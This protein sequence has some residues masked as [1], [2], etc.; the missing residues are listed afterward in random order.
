METTKLNTEE[1]KKALVQQQNEINDYT[2]YQALSQLEID[3]N[4]KKIFKKIAKEE[5]Y[6]YDFWVKITNQ[7]IKPNKLVV[8][9]YM[10]LVRIFGTSFALKSLEKEKLELKSFIKNY[11]IYIQNQK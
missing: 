4:N 8:W 5:K 9:W 3:E 11:L 7:E 2:I 1:L 6:H 10:L